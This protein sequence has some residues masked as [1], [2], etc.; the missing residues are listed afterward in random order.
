MFDRLSRDVIAGIVVLQLATVARRLQD[1]DIT[2]S[3]DPAVTDWLA[4]HGYDPLYGARPLKRLIQR[5][6]VDPMAMKVLD[7][8][9][10][11][12][13]TAQ[14]RLTPDESDAKMEAQE[15]QIVIEAID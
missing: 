7:G 15:A 5:E 3:V 1:Q 11:P 6:L 13:Q 8:S 4:D 10:G 12:E 9:L 2:L 14:V